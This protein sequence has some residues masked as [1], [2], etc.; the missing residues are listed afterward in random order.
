MGEK[1]FCSND[2][3][4]S[5][6]TQGHQLPSPIDDPSNQRYLCDYTMVYTGET[7]SDSSVRIKRN[8]DPKARKDPHSLHSKVWESLWGQEKISTID[9][10][11]F[12]VTVLEKKVPPGVFSP[13]WVFLKNG[14]TIGLHP[15][16]SYPLLSRYGY[17]NSGRLVSTVL[18]VLHFGALQLS[19]IRSPT[20][21]LWSIASCTIRL[22][23]SS[24]LCFFVTFGPEGETLLHRR[25]RVATFEAMDG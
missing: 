6:Q 17:A 18:R 11:F 25:L 23:H 8:M 4:L 12:I 9:E 24:R 7:K 1:P 3:G 5:I 21:T 20:S 22:S 2:A 14:D 19:R 15:T 10:G 13:P 16:T